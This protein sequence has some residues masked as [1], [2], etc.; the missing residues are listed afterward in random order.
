MLSRPVLPSGG[1]FLGN[2]LFGEVTNLTGLPEELIGEELKQ[3]LA[4]KGVS[5]DQV[6]MES[7]REA[8]ASYLTEI[9]ESI[10][11]EEATAEQVSVAAISAAEAA[12]S[13]KSRL[14]TQ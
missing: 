8:L 10:N 9:H 2:K 12:M 11:A 6:T 13:A 1:E 7:L 3:L 14:P 4:N 5:E